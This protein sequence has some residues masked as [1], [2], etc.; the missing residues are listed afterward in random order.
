L[1]SYE[2][3]PLTNLNLDFSPPWALSLW[4]MR[5]FGWH[6]DHDLELD[7]TMITTT[8]SPLQT[9]RQ[10]VDLVRFTW[11]RNTCMCKFFACSLFV[12]SSYCVNQHD[13]LRLILIF[14]DTKTQSEPWLLSTHSSLSG[15]WRHMADFKI[16]IWT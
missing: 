3:K 13:D 6:Q 12:G 7:A 8:F 9:A 2:I 5:T 15:T 4:H 16:R 11:P 1:T 10:L 14:Y